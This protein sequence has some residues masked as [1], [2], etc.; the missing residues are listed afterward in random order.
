MGTVSNTAS[1]VGMSFHTR[2]PTETV[3][4]LAAARCLHIFFSLLAGRIVSLM[5]ERDNIMIT[6]QNYLLYNFGIN[7][8]IL[9]GYLGQI[10]IQYALM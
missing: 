6:V 10:L 3:L 4:Y 5:D 2:T 1:F 8:S 9:V 7:M